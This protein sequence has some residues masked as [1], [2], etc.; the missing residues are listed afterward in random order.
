MIYIPDGNSI[1]EETPAKAGVCFY[2]A[3]NCLTRSRSGTCSGSAAESS[4]NH[5]IKGRGRQILFF[6]VQRLVR[7]KKFIQGLVKKC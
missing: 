4:G 5:G 3:K 2:L 6:D 1:D 7:I